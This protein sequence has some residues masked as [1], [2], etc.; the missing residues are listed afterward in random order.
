MDEMPFL[1]EHSRLNG[2]PCPCEDRGIERDMKDDEICGF[3][4]L[5]Q[6]KDWFTLNEIINLRAE[7][8]II[9]K[10]EVETITAYGQK[11]VLAIPKK[12]NYDE[13][14]FYIGNNY[15]K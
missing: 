1:Q 5:R 12:D 13:N 9:T 11:Q 15:K 2:R 4:S 14:G 8:F 3:I 7:E 10:V 6:L